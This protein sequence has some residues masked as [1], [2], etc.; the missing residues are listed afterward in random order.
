MSFLFQ[1][2]RTGVQGDCDNQNSEIIYEALYGLKKTKNNCLNTNINAGLN[3]T[4]LPYY[5]IQKF[6]EFRNLC[7]PIDHYSIYAKS[8]LDHMKNSYSGEFQCEAECLEIKFRGTTSITSS[9]YN[10]KAFALFMNQSFLYHGGSVKRQK[11]C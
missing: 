9:N 10:Q 3:C 7:T 11:C 4:I 8:E 2:D 6:K 1:Y 5:G